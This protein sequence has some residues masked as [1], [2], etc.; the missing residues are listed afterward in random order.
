MG[1]GVGVMRWR[2]V[3]HEGPACRAWC[4]LEGGYRAAVVDGV[5]AVLRMTRW[6]RVAAATAA[7]TCAS[8][9]CC[10]YYCCCF[11]CCSCG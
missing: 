2:V 8:S 7:A 5:V 6:R 11:R 9:C 3:V 1:V 4:D 10:C